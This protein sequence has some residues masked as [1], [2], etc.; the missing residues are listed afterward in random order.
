MRAAP[1][2]RTSVGLSFLSLFFVF[3]TILVPNPVG[4]VLNAVVRGDLRTLIG[5]P[6]G[7]ALILYLARRRTRAQFKTRALSALP[8]ERR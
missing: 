6:I 2:T 3:G 1:N 8:E 5:I 7:G 4:K